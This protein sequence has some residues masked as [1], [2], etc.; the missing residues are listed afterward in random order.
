M[1][2]SKSDGLEVHHIEPRKRNGASN[3]SNLITLCQRCHEKVTGEEEKYGEQFRATIGSV[4]RNLA[5]TAQVNSFKEYILSAITL[6]HEE[7]FGYI[8]KHKRKELG[9]KKSHAADAIAIG[10]KDK[11]LPLVVNCEVKRCRSQRRAV[12][13][14]YKANPQKGRGFVRYRQ[15][16]NQIE[17][18]GRGDICWHKKKKC[19]VI[20]DT[21]LT[22]GKFNASEVKSGKRIAS[23][24][25]TH[26]KLLR[27][28][29]SL[30]F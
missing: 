9:L 25:P 16:F 21:L 30:L 5:K 23:I 19:R 24:S 1:C 26:L 22:T 6:P 15:P 4:K 29:Y 3:P 28:K 17:G 14:Q 13:Q 10:I 11:A 8:T 27:T 12:R 7:T 18:I 20:I 2:Q